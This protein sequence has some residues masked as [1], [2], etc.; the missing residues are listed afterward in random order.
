[1]RA[2]VF[3]FALGFVGYR[4]RRELEV[5]SRQYGP[6][7]LRRCRSAAV[8][9]KEKLQDVG[10]RVRSSAST[11]AAA[12]AASHNTKSQ[13]VSWGTCLQARVTCLFVCGLPAL[14]LGCEGS[15][16][17]CADEE[18]DLPVGW[19]VDGWMDRWMDG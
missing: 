9:G 13:K 7:L 18:G 15:V 4:Y 1:M 14:W 11:F 6:G 2:L 16:V 3:L 10:V 12:A 5:W 17:V 19:L 8:A